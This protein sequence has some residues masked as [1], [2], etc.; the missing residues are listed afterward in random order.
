MRSRLHLVWPCRPLLS[1]SRCSPHRLS[2]TRRHLSDDAGPEHAGWRA[3]RLGAEWAA[4]AW[5][6]RS[7]MRRPG[8]R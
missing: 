7:G 4:A 6:M 2:L 5:G 8:W 3:A 1:C